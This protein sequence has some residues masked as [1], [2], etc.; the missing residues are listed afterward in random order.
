M[1]MGENRSC[2]WDLFEIIT[3]F[4]KMCFCPDIGPRVPER[5]ERQVV[6]GTGGRIVPNKELPK[7]V[8]EPGLQV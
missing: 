6:K 1:G 4:I 8:G 7:T 3:T 5:T 2:N